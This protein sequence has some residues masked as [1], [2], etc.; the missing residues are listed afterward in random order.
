MILNYSKHLIVSVCFRCKCV[1][2]P[3]SDHHAT[4]SLRPSGENTCVFVSLFFMLTSRVGVAMT[5]MGGIS[6][7]FFL[8]KYVIIM[9]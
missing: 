3:V 4:D 5:T 6:L 9:K 7:K 2:V 8:T 1:H